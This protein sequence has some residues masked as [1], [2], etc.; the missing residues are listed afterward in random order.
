MKQFA[1]ALALVTGVGLIALDAEKRII[2]NDASPYLKQLFPQAAAFSPHQGTPLHY[3][4]YA[5]DPKTN[6]GANP[7]GFVFWTTDLTPNEYAYHGHIHMLV[8]MDMTGILTGVLVNFNSEPYGYFSVEPQQ[9]AAQFKGK[10][11]RAP[12]RV[13][14]DVHAVTRATISISSATRAIRDSS[15]TIARTFLDPASVK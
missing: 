11:I 2:T 4:A 6:P 9:F 15:R 14:E 3:K 5:V 8:G 1:V 7:I 13:G 12:F 10:S